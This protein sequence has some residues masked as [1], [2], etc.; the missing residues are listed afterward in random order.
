[1]K[2]IASVICLLAALNFAT[3]LP[4]PNF[5]SSTGDGEWEKLGDRNVDFT[6]DKD[7]ILVTG[8]QGQFSALKL[9]SK[10]GAIKITKVVVHFGNG[11]EQVLD[12]PNEI[13]NGKESKVF[14]LVGDDRSIN[15]VEFWYDTK[16][17]AG[18]KAEIEL[19]GKR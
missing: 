6:L 1:M 9:K 4:T 18:K 8:I 15:R 7:V 14:D 12:T 11:T 10:A 2:I 17:Y 5:Y 19:W 16:G 13:A 3:A